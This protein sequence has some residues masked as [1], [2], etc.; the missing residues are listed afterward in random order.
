MVQNLRFLK[1]LSAL[2]QSMH[3]GLRGHGRYSTLS[4]HLSMVIIL[5]SI[6]LP[7]VGA[8]LKADEPTRMMITELFDE[9]VQP[10]LFKF[11]G[12]RVVEH[13]QAQ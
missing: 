2:L 1:Y 4:C 8:P 12:E 5:L 11:C 6:C 10:L 9:E 13:N 7:E 3:C